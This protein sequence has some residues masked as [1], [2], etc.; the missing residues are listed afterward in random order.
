MDVSVDNGAIERT[1]PDSSFISGAFIAAPLLSPSDLFYADILN[2]LLG[3]N[4]HGLFSDSV[5][6]FSCDRPRLIYSI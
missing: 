5:W 6:I 4:R 1:V 3:G 2:Y